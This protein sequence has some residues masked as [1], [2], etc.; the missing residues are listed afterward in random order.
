MT[1]SGTAN[2]ASTNVGTGITVT[3]TAITLSGAQASNY[4]VSNSIATTT[5]SITARA[6]T[7]NIVAAAKTYDGTT[8]ASV[9]Y[10]LTGV[11]SGDAVTVTGAGAVF[12][13]SNVGIFI[14]V[15]A[16]GITIGGASAGNYALVS[17]SASATANI[18]AKTLV[19][20]IVANNKTYDGTTAASAVYALAGV[21]GGDSVTGGGTA[22]FAGK[23]AG[24]GIAVTASG[25][26]LSGPAAGN[27]KVNATASGATANITQLAITGSITVA[28]AL[29]FL[30][31]ASYS[32][33][34][35]A[36]GKSSA[37]STTIVST[38]VPVT[39]TVIEVS[40]TMTGAAAGV[41]VAD[42]KTIAPLSKVVIGDVIATH[43]ETVTV[44][45]AEPTYGSLTVGTT[46]FVAV[47]PG[48]YTL[49][50][51]PAAVTKAIDGLIFVPT[52][53]LVVPG[54]TV[55][56]NF[57]VSDFDGAATTTNTM[58]T[59]ISTSVNDAPTIGIPTTTVAGKLVSVGASQTT[60]DQST[61]APFTQV[62]INDPDVGQTLTVTVTLL[63]ANGKFTVASLAA[64]G[65]DGGVAS[66]KNTVY[67]L[68]NAAAA[69]GQTAAQ[70][71]TAALA[72]LVFQP[73][74]HETTPLKT[75]T[76]IFTIG[77]SD[78][79]NGVSK[80]ITNVSTTV[81]ATAVNDP[82]TISGVTL[83]TAEAV[84]CRHGCRRG[85]PGGGNRDDHAGQSGRRYAG[86]LVQSGHRSRRQVYLHGNARRR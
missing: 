9:T 2:F 67:T 76:T 56:E 4:T 34:V 69:G 80:A 47:A 41:A 75:V 10:S 66:A 50:G 13:Q 43:G 81:I 23:D 7:A 31:R 27:Y 30:H 72:Q 26:T 3:A 64:A 29:D 65:F 53:N 14:P 8:T 61:I 11:V 54:G 48:V 68:T 28:G 1:A 73:A 12:G 19:A 5:S 35:V 59:V 25:I 77:V 51:T 45:L 16:T 49:T 20:G 70:V 15:T 33:N 42:N 36:S 78:S 32:F 40:P 71:A 22:V 24:T 83:D 55:T 62:T 86:R 18:I 85:F 44:T 57:T 21:V 37:T 60:T 63:A 39:V 74:A 82:P 46:G 84:Q 17:A 6:L 52:R 38:S 58:A 79:P